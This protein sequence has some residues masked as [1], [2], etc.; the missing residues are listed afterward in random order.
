MIKVTIDL[1]P[2][3]LEKN[4]KTLYT[5]DIAN[6]GTGDSTRGNYKVRYPGKEW[7]E[8]VVTN[9]PRQSYP[10]LKLVYKVLKAKYD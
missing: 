10:V 8:K 9:W 6:D 2:F 7:E 4:K 1:W 3:G 5:F